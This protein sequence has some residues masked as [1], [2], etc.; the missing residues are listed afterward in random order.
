VSELAD[1]YATVADGFTRVVD[2]VP[3]D[4]WDRP[5]PCAGWVA[6]DVVGHLAEW[7]PAFFGERWGITFDAPA[8]ADDPAGAWHA[9][10]DA[11]RSARATRGTETA[12]T[13]FGV[14][15]LEQTLDM[16]VTGDV[17]IH[18]WDLARATGGDERLDP[19]EVHRMFEG[20]APM[21][22]ALR[23]SGHFGPKVDVAADAAEQDRLLAFTG[24]D[25][26]HTGM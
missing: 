23:W 17:L 16:I 8:V 15:P 4:G 5:A 25:P 14:Q 11:L 10:D 6:R 20:M 12:E 9:L 1:R 3:A 18:T 7:V 24:R 21:D 19:V 22:E 2:A 13:P 26:R